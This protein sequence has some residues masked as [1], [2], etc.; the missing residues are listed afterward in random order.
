MKRMIY[1]GV[2]LVFSWMLTTQAALALAEVRSTALIHK[3]T[4]T[5]GDLLD[6]LDRGHD[7]W[8]MN[9][10]A[11]GKKTSVSTKYLASLTRQHNVYWQNSRGVQQVTVTRKG[12][13]IKHEA[14]E[15]MIMQELETLNMSDRKKGIRF[16]NK[17]ATIHLPEDNNIEDITIQKFSLDQQTGKFSATVS[18][19]VGEGKFTTSVVHGRSHAVSYVPALNRIVAPGRQ[20][21]DRDIAWVAMP[22]LSIGRNIIHNKNQLIG[23]TP[24]RGLNPTTPLRTS[25]L[26]RPEI[27]IRGKMVSILFKSGK[28]NLTAIGKAIESGGRGDVIRVMNSKSHKTIEAVVTG[29]AQ[30][31]VITTQYGLAQL[32]VLQ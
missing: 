7:I 8:V 30:V 18:A 21:T 14:L 10:P 2:I 27:V 24:K 25:D 28:I 12:N 17:N 26:K 15:S 20:I 31:Q 4:I 11:P 23:M 19:P 1:R 13:V 5:L 32:N 29:P 16:D 9:A 22:T 6:N 3:S